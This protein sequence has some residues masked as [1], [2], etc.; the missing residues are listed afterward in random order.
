MQSTIMG[1]ALLK[2]D[3]REKNAANAAPKS[4]K[5]AESWLLT[6]I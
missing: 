2:K 1:S 4:E 5:G 6:K 3:E